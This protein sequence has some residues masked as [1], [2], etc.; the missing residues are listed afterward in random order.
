MNGRIKQDRSDKFPHIQVT[1]VVYQEK[2]E[3]A[4]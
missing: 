1:D 4:I 2:I 3:I